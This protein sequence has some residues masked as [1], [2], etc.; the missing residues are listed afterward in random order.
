MI[1]VIVICTV[2][3]AVTVGLA[4]SAIINAIQ[5]LTYQVA[6]LRKETTAGLGVESSDQNGYAHGGF[7]SE[8]A[9]DLRERREQERTERYQRDAQF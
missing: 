8:M 2:A 6:W 7:L 5:R 3:L 1:W 9:T 4:A